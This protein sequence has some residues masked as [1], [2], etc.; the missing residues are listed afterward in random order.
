M[1]LYIQEGKCSSDYS[2]DSIRL[3]SNSDHTS[4][5]AEYY[6]PAVFRKD[7]N[8]SDSDLWSGA[9]WKTRAGECTL[10]SAS[11]SRIH[12]RVYDEQKERQGGFLLILQDVKTVLMATVTWPLCFHSDNSFPAESSSRKRFQF[13]C[14]LR[15]V[16]GTISFTFS[17][18]VLYTASYFALCGTADTMASA[19]MISLTLIV[20]ASSGTSLIVS[21]QPSFTCC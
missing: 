8:R 12:N 10:C 3:D 20:I 2:C 6:N 1:V 7:E 14:V 21:N 17:V 13:L 4:S 11:C 19:F 9:G 18:I 15:M 16:A 5:G